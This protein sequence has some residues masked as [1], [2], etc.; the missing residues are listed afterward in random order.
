MQTSMTNSNTAPKVLVLGATGGIGGHVAAKLAERGWSVRALHRK[1]DEQVRRK[2]AYEWMQGDAMYAG[3]VARAADGVELIVHA[4]NPPGYKDWQKL[5]LP[6]LQNTIAAAKREGA[7]I[8]LPGTVYNFGPDAFPVLSEDSPQNPVTVKGKIRVELE[9]RLEAAS[10]EGAPVLIVRAGD[11]F[12]PSAGN[13]WFSQG[14]VK[15][16]K[17]ITTVSQPNTK[18]VGH[19]W[20]YLPDVAETMV[21]LVEKRDELPAFARFHM[22]GF[23]DADGS[24]MAA[25]IERVVGHKVKRKS[26]PWG[27]FRLASPFLPILREL[28]EM[29][30]LWEQPVRM[31]NTKL[32]AILGEEPRTALDEAV[33][34]TLADLGCLEPDLR[35]DAGHQAAS[36]QFKA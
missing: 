11:F 14:L 32:L 17:P 16:G 8:L 6:M 12:G 19:Q 22:E 13:S 29:R 4:V 7:R 18:G 31:R 9:Q 15:P 24:G 33:H 36:A 10:R 25:A 34:A 2:P 28:L 26:V 27:M 3:D 5:V 21:R 23:W 1:A 35:K 20:A 30:Y